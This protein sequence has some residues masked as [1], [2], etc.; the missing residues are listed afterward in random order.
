MQYRNVPGAV[1]HYWAFVVFTSVTLVILV[2]LYGF[3]RWKLC[4][5]SVFCMVT[6][7]SGLQV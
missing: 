5:A 2:A 6:L 4:L 7:L 1:E 3:I